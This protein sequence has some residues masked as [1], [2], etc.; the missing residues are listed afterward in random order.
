MK[1]EIDIKLLNIINT[2]VVTQSVTKTA[3]QLKLSPGSI[4]YALKKARSI[5]GAHLFIRTRNGMKPDTTAKEL[6]Q[7]YQKFTGNS[8]PPTFSESATGKNT[9]NI[10]TFTPVEMMLAKIV[11][12][13][14]FWNSDLRFNFFPY[15][16]N[17]NDRLE[18]I[19]NG[20]IDIDIGSKLPADKLV[21]KIKLFSTPV[22]LLASQHSGLEDTVTLTDWQE[23][24]HAVWSVFS[25]YYCDNVLSSQ[26][27]VRYMDERKI[28]MI[29][30][31]II[32]MVAFCANSKCIMMIPD[33]F[34]HVFTSTFP[35]KK[36]SM[37]PEL[38]LKYDCYFHF[39]NTL[40]DYEEMKLTANE[41]VS[42]FKNINQVDHDTFVTPP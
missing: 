38:S 41:I 40:F 34:A 22:S 4:S 12:E 33:Y 26:D 2:L 14:C 29:S 21:N 37:P 36:L 39:S 11:K 19:K 42:H 5:T 10:M 24:K 13:S 23:R 28:A 31:S 18:R 16:S 15:D 27:V 35:V 3:Q 20:L 32:N 6:S 7:R 1:K 25:D 30:A 17:S 8:M 9:L